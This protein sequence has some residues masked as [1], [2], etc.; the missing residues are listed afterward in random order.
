MTQTIPAFD[1][2]NLN[3]VKVYEPSPPQ[4]GDE[5]YGWRDAKTGAYSMYW[6]KTRRGLCVASGVPGEGQVQAQVQRDTDLILD[7]TTPAP[8]EVKFWMR[9][10]AT[11]EPD[12]REFVIWALE[13]L[14]GR[15]TAERRVTAA[16]L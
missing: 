3:G 9:S 2:T 4:P 14:L 10:G 11:L 8:G 12:E 5:G 16:T 1:L 7:V 15:A 13:P 6:R